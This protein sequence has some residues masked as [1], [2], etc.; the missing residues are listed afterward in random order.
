[1]IKTLHDL[2]PARQPHPAVTAGIQE[3]LRLALR[4]AQRARDRI[5]ISALRTTLAAIGNAGAVPA[6]SAKPSGTI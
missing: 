3:R 6:D 4:E 2:R 1:M 5:A